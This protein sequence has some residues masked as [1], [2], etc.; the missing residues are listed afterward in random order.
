MNKTEQNILNTAIK[1]LAQ[2]PSATMNKV[3]DVAGISRMTLHRYFNNKQVLLEK[4]FQELVR[5]VKIIVENALACSD[6]PLEQ[7]EQM[8]K[9]DTSLGNFAFLSQFSDEFQDEA[10]ME[11]FE[12]LNASLNTLLEALKAKG[13]IEP[14]LSTS[15]LNHF[16]CAVL[17]A[18]WKAFQ[19]GSVAPN[20]IPELA[21]QSFSK[22]VIKV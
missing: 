20:D 22:G 19:D 15:W 5:N 4:A 9:G 8:I 1:I 7:L 11:E 6:N 10:M 17:S 18:A 12:A 16:Y 3:A 13:V 14:S 21:W 2:D